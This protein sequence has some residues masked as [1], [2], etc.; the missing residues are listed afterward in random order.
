MNDPVKVFVYFNIRRKDF[1]IRALEG[2]KRGR[3]I[4]H[5]AS[6]EII[7]A[8]F[9]V[10]E[11]GR[12][13]VLATGV[14]NIHAGVRGTLGELGEKPQVPSREAIKVT[15]NPKRDTG[16]IGAVSRLPVPT[17]ASRVVL[18]S[19]GVYAEVR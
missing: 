6:V 3:V 4:G 10:S 7:D 18:S 13:R 19:E 11:A 1:S 12:R 5:A 8:E 15:Y 9:R 17:R 16:F 2:P 14:K